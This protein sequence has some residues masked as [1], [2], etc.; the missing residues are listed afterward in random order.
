MAIRER[1]NGLAD[2]SHATSRH[3]F[4][5]LM[6]DNQILRVDDAAG[7]LFFDAL[8]LDPRSEIFR[9]QT[10]SRGAAADMWDADWYDTA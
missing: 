5:S 3:P 4:N 10:P 1:I 7:V 2:S 8:V 6:A 9:L